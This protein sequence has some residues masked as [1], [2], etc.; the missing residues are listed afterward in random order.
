[1]KLKSVD[2]KGEHDNQKKIKVVDNGE[3]GMHNTLYG[4]MRHVS[5]HVENCTNVEVTHSSPDV[6]ANAKTWHSM[7]FVKL[8]P[9][10]KMVYSK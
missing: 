9:Q 6:L 1:M 5:G 10:L 3:Q 7:G 2:D 4:T 8:E